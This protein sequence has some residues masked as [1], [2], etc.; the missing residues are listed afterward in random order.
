MSNVLI[1]RPYQL[2]AV[3]EAMGKN[4]IIN[5]KTGGGKTLI[6]AIV[7]DKFLK[8]SPKTICFLV[9]SKALVDQQT[10]YLQTNCETNNGMQICVEGSP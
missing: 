7:I 8:L 1:P 3:E 2:M 10:K 5:I 9:P 6:A 4:T